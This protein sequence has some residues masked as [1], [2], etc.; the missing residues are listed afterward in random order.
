MRLPIVLTALVA[1]AACAP[2]AQVTKN[3]PLSETGVGFGTP[4]GLVAGGGSG[5]SSLAR[6]FMDLTFAME[7]GR[8]L[9]T[10]SRFEGPVTVGLTGDVPPTAARDLAALVGRLRDEAGIDISVTEPDGASITVEF[11]SRSTLRQLAPQA[12]CF[13]VPNVS[14]LAEYRRKRGTAEVDW[15]TVTRRDR[16][17]I[18]V[19][20]DTSPQEIRDCLHEELAQA[21]GPLNDLYRLPDSVFNDDNFHSVLTGFDMTILR[22]VYSPALASGMSRAEVA[23][24]LPQ[25]L[26]GS[27]LGS[28]AQGVSPWVRAIETALGRQGS[29]TA[30]KAAADQALSL[31]EAAGWQDGRLAFSHF[32]IARLNA[33]SDPERAYQAFTR[34]AAIYARQPSGALQVAHIDMQL[35]AMALSGGLPKDAL[36]LADRAIPVVKSYENAALLATLMLIKAEALERLG[37]TA[38]A[39]ALRVDSQPLARYGFGPDAVVQARMR[40]IAA[41]AD[42][43]ANG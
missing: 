13:V 32:A 40:D 5:G 3:R 30:R 14:S 37:D 25:L 28:T 39:E 38:A 9:D 33:G 21:L 1:L 29:A 11:T 12:A 20:A 24:K 17:A 10:F 27:S 2:S 8:M 26:G 18:F 43:G 41:V 36:Q 19:P 16:A 31:A 15:A 4:T 34:A 42:R 23:A 35:A 22:A 7:S 6:D